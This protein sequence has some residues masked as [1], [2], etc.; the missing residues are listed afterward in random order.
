MEERAGLPRTLTTFC[1][2]RWRRGPRFIASVSVTCVCSVSN[3]RSFKKFRPLAVTRP[4]HSSR[5][6][7]ECD[8]CPRP[9]RQ[10][11]CF[12]V[13]SLCPG[14]EAVTRHSV[15]ATL[16]LDNPHSS[17]KLRLKCHLFGAYETSHE[18]SQSEL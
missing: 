10:E 14:L 8:P 18:S 1:S 5:R 3:T 7:A 6:P 2:S 13:P 12:P 4:P 17:N 16:H 11:G 9:R 15:I